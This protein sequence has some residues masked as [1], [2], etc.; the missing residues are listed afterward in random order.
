PQSG[1][2]TD[3]RIDSETRRTRPRRHHQRG[4][5]PAE[6]TRNYLH[7][8]QGPL[9][10]FARS[11]TSSAGSNLLYRRLEVSMAWINTAVQAWVRLRPNQKLPTSLTNHTNLDHPAGD[12][13]FIESVRR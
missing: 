10:A 3:R 9:I 2:Q 13:M 1:R 5:G 7:P 6:G 4:A 12:E 8:D 11:V